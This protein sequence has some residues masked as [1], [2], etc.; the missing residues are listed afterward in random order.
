MTDKYCP[1][2]TAT[3]IIDLPVLAT[4]RLPVIAAI[5]KPV[6]PPRK[7]V[8]DQISCLFFV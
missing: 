2:V 7:I 6:L 5:S 8:P 4:S 1:K 3:G